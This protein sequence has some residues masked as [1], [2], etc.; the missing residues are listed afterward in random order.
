MDSGREA[1]EILFTT[2]TRRHGGQLVDQRVEAGGAVD[3]AQERVG[4]IEDQVEELERW[5]GMA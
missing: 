5:D 1:E 3:S 4:W 2:E